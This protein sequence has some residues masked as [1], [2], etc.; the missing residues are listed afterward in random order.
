MNRQPQNAGLRIHSSATSKTASRRA[1]GPPFVP[2]T[3]ASNQA[4]N[5]SWRPEVLVERHLGGARL[6]EDAVDPGGVKTIA[7]EQRE[8]GVDDCFA[9][10]TH[11]TAC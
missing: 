10:F 9:S 2:L 8:R 4:R 1:R 11:C 5:V 7:L 3:R 6:G